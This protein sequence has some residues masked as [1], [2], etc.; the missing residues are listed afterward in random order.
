MKRPIPAETMGSAYAHPVAQMIAPAS[1]TPRLATMSES[2][3]RYAPRTFRLPSD[4][5]F[6]RNTLTMLV[7]RA[8]LAI[9]TMGP[10]ATSGG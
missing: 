7:S 2:T 3:S 10:A 5:F 4:P 8:A 1:M 6:S 9:A